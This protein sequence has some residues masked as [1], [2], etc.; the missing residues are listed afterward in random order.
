MPIKYTARPDPCRG[1]EQKAFRNGCPPSASQAAPRGRVLGLQHPRERG[2]STP[3]QQAAVPRDGALTGTAALSH[4]AAPT[5]Q[6]TAF[7]ALKGASV[8]CAVVKISAFLSQ[9]SQT[10]SRSGSCWE[11]PSPGKWLGPAAPLAGRH[12]AEPSGDGCWDDVLPKTANYWNT[13]KEK[14]IT[15]PFR[16]C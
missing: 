10:S 11:P 1:D 3:G 12:R 14:P 4:L 9:A 6:T 8:A 16:R 5:L 2:P 13:K 7:I 15:T